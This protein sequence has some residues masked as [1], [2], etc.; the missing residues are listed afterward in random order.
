MT[1]A[2]FALL[3]KFYPPEGMFLTGISDFS[4]ST[5][6][7]TGTFNVPK[8]AEYSIVPL[9]YVTAEQY[10]RCFSQLSYALMYLLSIYH[11]GMTFYSTPAEFERL[12][13]GGK[14]WY[15]RL[16]TRYLRQT[17]K[18]S[19]FTLHAQAEIRQMGSFAIA[20]IVGTGPARFFGEFVV[21]IESA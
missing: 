20:R 19:S 14:M 8:A 13:L 4:V 1:E 21:P 2:A 11:D 18:G 12:M 7:A 6:S 9:D 10:V 17:M 3:R 5:S 15:R 16:D